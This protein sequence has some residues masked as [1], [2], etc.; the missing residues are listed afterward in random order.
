MNAPNNDF[1]QKKKSFLQI[2][3]LKAEKNELEK[4]LN[5]EKAK[6]EQMERRHQE[7]KS[8]EDKKYADEIQFLKKTNQQLKV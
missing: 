3:L 6:Y 7:Q 2:E 8:L 1:L 4:Q 5:E